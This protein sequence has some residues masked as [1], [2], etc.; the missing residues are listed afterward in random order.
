MP[1]YL[2]DPTPC[3][4]VNVT[5]SFCLFRSERHLCKPRGVALGAPPEGGGRKSNKNSPDHFL[6]IFLYVIL[7]Y[8]VRQSLMSEGTACPPFS[9]LCP[10]LLRKHSAWYTWHI[11]VTQN[12]H[13]QPQLQQ[14]RLA[15]CMLIARGFGHHVLHRINLLLPAPQIL[16]G[17]EVIT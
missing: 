1:V 15:G 4:Y 10:R 16:I 17:M 8:D 5:F 2:S 7:W 12:F 6:Q 11:P 9:R 3:Q 14:E 13:P